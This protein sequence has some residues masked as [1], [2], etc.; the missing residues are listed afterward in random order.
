MQ[1]HDISL[2]C[3]K[4]LFSVCFIFVVQSQLKYYED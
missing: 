4:Y 2:G 1:N 3:D